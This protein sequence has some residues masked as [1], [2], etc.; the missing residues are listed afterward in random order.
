[1]YAENLFALQSY[2]ITKLQACSV[3]N[4]PIVVYQKN[5]LPYMQSICLS[6]DTSRTQWRDVLSDP[7]VT[8]NIYCK[9]RNLPNT[10]TQNDLQICGNFWVTQ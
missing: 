1:M 9:S 8:A 6:Y 5:D 3:K 7:E 10:D 2:Q 4:A